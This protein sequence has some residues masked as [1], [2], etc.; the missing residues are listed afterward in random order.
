MRYT[1]ACVHVWRSSE[2]L[3]EHM[4]TGLCTS[5][6]CLKPHWWCISQNL[7]A[8]IQ[9]LTNRE[10]LKIVENMIKGGLAS[11]SDERYF[12]VN[13]KYMENYDSALES[14]FCF[15]VD[16]FMVN[17]E[18]R[19]STRWWIFAGGSPTWAGTQCTDQ[20]SHRLHP[21]NIFGVPTQYRRPLS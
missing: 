16:A 10:H 9:L 5:I 21:W 19:T 14:T 2:T 13:N 1:F 4:W 18:N 17:H 3:Y 7:R 6:Q 8:N 15:M 12:K 11:V 20:F